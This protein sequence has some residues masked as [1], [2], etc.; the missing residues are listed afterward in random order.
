M[1]NAALRGKE[2]YDTFEF[3]AGQAACR[4]DEPCPIDASE[5]FKAGYGAQYELE[6]IQ[7]EM[8]K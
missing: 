4:D 8:T 5:S 1:S 3:I 7:S 6:Q 2:N